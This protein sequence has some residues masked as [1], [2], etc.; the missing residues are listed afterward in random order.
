MKSVISPPALPLEKEQELGV[1]GDPAAA[2]GA[3][4]FVPVRSPGRVLRFCCRCGF[5]ERRRW[6]SEEGNTKKLQV[7]TQF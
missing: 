2:G 5:S 3:E 7:K 4:Q 1:R 6:H